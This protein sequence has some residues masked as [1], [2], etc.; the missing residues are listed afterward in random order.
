MIGEKAFCNHK[1]N[2]VRLVF[3]NG[4][5]IST[6]WGCGTYSENHDYSSG[7]VV[8]DYTQPIKDGSS[9]AEIM[10]LDAPEGVIEK[11]YKHQKADVQNGVIGWVT[12]SDWLWVIN[13]LAKVEGGK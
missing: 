1:I 4:N 10:I 3:P 2:G 13:Q 8:K 7:D 6:V 12:I 5:A 9:T 11:I